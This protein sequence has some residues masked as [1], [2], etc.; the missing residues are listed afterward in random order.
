MTEGGGARP[1]TPRWGLQTG[2]HMG[3]P[4]LNFGAEA[5]RRK[6]ERGEIEVHGSQITETAHF[7]GPHWVQVWAV[8]DGVAVATSRQEVTIG[9]KG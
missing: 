7:E 8:R 6:M 2:A 1:Y 3:T 5:H 9:P 4:L